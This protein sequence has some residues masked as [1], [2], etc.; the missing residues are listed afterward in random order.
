MTPTYLLYLD[1]AHLEDP[2]FVPSM[3]RMMH[4]R[5]ALPRCV[6]V[7]GS[8]GEVERQFEAEGLFPETQ[9]G[10]VLPES[11]AEVALMQR[12]LK[13]TTRTIVGALVEEIIY[14]VGFQGT[15]RGL[16]QWESDT[17]TL[18][19]TD[20]LLP[21]IAQ[22][23]LPV[24]SALAQAPNDSPRQVA[25]HAV[26]LA[27]AD[28]FEAPTVVCFTRNNQ[29]GFFHD[30]ALRAQVAAA[31]IPEA[32][33]PNVTAFRAFADAGYPILLTS[34]VGLFGG[35]DLQATRIP[36]KTA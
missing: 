18:G 7:H 10:L 25:T 9:N 3:A 5:A 16:L 33:L 14:A 26:L 12:A 22:G 17:L 35:N 30:G 6:M 19:K 13:T 15:D 23:A 27:L 36:A 34:A 11:P 4:R 20:W 21:L 32:L 2:L 28:A 8:G 31:D 24:I 29:P 1:D